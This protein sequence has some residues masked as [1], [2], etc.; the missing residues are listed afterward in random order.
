MHFDSFDQPNDSSERSLIDSIFNREAPTYSAPGRPSVGSPIVIKTVSISVE[1][2]VKES[3]IEPKKS[4]WS[5]PTDWGTRNDKL[6]EPEQLSPTSP[7]STKVPDFTARSVSD[8]STRASTSQSESIAVATHFRRLIK[9]MESAS[10]QVVLDRIE[11]DW[12]STDD[13]AMQEELHIEKLLWALTALDSD[14]LSNTVSAVH[15]TEIKDGIAIHFEGSMGKFSRVSG[16]VP[17]WAD[18]NVADIYRSINKT[19]DS[20]VFYAC[21]GDLDTISHTLNTAFIHQLIDMDDYINLPL[22]LPNGMFNSVF[23]SSLP[24]LLPASG[25]PA[26]LKECYRLLAPNGQFEARLVNAQPERSTIGPKL[27]AWLEDNLIIQLETEFRCSRPCEVVPSWANS[28]GFRMPNG[29]KAVLGRAL[30]LQAAVGKS[31][32]ISTRIGSAILREIWQDSWGSCLTEDDQGNKQY[33]WDHEDIVQECL[34]RGTKWKAATF[35]VV[36]PM[37]R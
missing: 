20:K 14:I 18:L 15:S 6:R 5:A 22:P 24:T 31:N 3:M 35:I 32:D 25:I 11:E 19:T 2:N 16:F 27:S 36:K 21:N 9:R 10:P 8:G 1:S 34:E 29:S 26:F 23:V 7:T 33:W 30:M 17:S 12:G 28:A 13:N 4:K 37:N